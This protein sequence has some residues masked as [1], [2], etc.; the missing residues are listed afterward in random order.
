MLI[1]LLDNA[2]KA[3]LECGE[4]V[5][6]AY[7]SEA[8][9]YTTILEVRD[10]GVGIPAEHLEYIFD[11]FY[12]TDRSRTHRDGQNKGAGLGLA[13][14]K[15]IA[16]A[17]GADIEVFSTIGKGTTIRLSFTTVPPRNNQQ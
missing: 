1:N 16:E 2:I 17:N 8:P 15:Q 9:T 11:P 14:A 13:L 10:E 4:I 3:S 5:L 12:K 7:V 6:A